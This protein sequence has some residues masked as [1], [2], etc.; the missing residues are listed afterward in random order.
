MLR[1]TLD[2][3][4]EFQKLLWWLSPT[5]M[6]VSNPALKFKNEWIIK[7][8][9]FLCHYSC[10]CPP[11]CNWKHS[12]GF[13]KT[14]GIWVLALLDL[15]EC[16]SLYASLYNFLSGVFL[17]WAHW[18]KEDPHCDS[19]IFRNTTLSELWVR[20]REGSSSR[21]GAREKNLSLCCACSWGEIICCLLG[22]YRTHHTHTHTALLPTL[23]DDWNVKEKLKF[24]SFTQ[25]CALSAWGKW[26]GS[27]NPLSPGV[28]PY[29][30]KW[31]HARAW[32]LRGESGNW[33][34][35]NPWAPAGITGN[36]HW[37]RGETF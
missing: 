13:I 5:E 14:Y 36:S 7:T 35:K 8:Y 9:M 26:T 15:W 4:H 10:N 1:S 31:C 24:I 34:D 32:P 19:V 21:H 20:L 23:W 11:L 33:L 28:H 16:L 17:A 18:P 12:N 30:M 22:D 3:C 27:Y 29:E 25:P 6:L 37:Q 2:K